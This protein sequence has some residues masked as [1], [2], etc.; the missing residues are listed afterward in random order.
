MKVTGTALHEKDVVEA[1]GGTY[2]A[3]STTASV[4]PDRRSM[5]VSLDLTSTPRT[6]LSLSVL[7]HDGVRH[8]RG[9]VTVVAPLQATA[10]PAVSGT[11]VV[12]GKV[13]AQVGTW[14]P[15]PTSF[16][17]QWY[18]NGRAVSGET[19]TTFVLTKAQRGLRITVRVTAYRT[20]HTA[21][22]A[23]SRSTVAVAG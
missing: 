13:T 11:A 23:W 10:A 21:G 3:R 20:G 22:V 19:K 14:T 18:A 4:A 8:S 2:R 1:S 9:T 12:A 7:R 15:A 17:Y 6:A 16:A 5:D